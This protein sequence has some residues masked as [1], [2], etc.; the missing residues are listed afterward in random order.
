MILQDIVKS[1]G[2]KIASAVIAL[3]A[4]AAG[5]WCYQ[6]PEEMRTFGRVVKYTLIWLVVTAAL[7]WSSFLFM[8]PFMDLQA[9]M[10]SAGAAQIASMGLIA[11][12]TGVNIFHAFWLASWDINGGMTWLVVILGFAAAAAY[13]FFICESLARHVDR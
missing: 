2:G 5:Y 7:P 12:Y 11:A 13:N 9:R 3:A 1:L 6:H 10:T 8:R 4:F